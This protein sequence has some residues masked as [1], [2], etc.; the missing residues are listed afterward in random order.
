MQ[1]LWQNYV[2]DAHNCCHPEFWKLHQALHGETTACRDAVLNVVRKMVPSA[3]GWPGSSRS[4][5]DRV[6]RHAGSFWPHV[7]QTHRI[8]LSEFDLPGL[9]SVEFSFVDPIFA[10]IQQ[11]N[12]LSK[13]DISLKWDP[14]RLLHPQTG[15]R[16][17]GAGIE[18]G[19]LL[20]AVTE[21]VPPGAKVAL[22]NLSWDGG[23]TGYVGRSACP[24]CLGVMNTNSQTANAVG[25]LGY[26]PYVEVDK[27]IKGYDKAK[28][29]VLQA[30]IGHILDS[31]EVRSR[32]GFRYVYC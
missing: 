8:D 22:M 14:V 23:G 26:V 15:E 6:R 2:R 19:H 29:H 12:D 20:H 7:V 13:A 18:C 24:I 1:K 25:L 3:G 4:L 28:K 5:R 11:C 21:T 10:F 16:V 30:C 17:Y 31:I 32:Y 9:S 27:K